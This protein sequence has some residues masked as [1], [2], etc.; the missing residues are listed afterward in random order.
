MIV[1]ATERVI[2]Y[3]IP[4]SRYLASG[5]SF[6]DLHFSYQIGISTASKIVKAVCFSIWSIMCPE[7][8]PRPTKERKLIALEFERRANFLHSLGSVNGKH[9]S[10]QTGT[11]WLDV[12]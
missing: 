6:H 12:L 2:N 9:S 5:C 3:R 8:I 7:C 1:Q 11:Q 10:N 4:F